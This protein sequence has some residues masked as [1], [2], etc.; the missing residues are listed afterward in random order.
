MYSSYSLNRISSSFS[1]NLLLKLKNIINKINIINVDP[2]G[3]NSTIP[4]PVV[5]TELYIGC[6]TY[7][8][9]PLSL[10]LAVFL[11]TGVAVKEDP[12]LRLAIIAIIIPIR[13]RITPTI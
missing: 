4:K 11:G 12:R 3:L 8:Y 6:L 13:T 10:N 2:A 7:L 5:S 9:K 1:S